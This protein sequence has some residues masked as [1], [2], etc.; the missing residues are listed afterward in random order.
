MHKEHGR[1]HRPQH[2]YTHDHYSLC[3]SYSSSSVSGSLAVSSRSSS[4]DIHS[5]YF[6]V[7]QTAGLASLPLSLLGRPRSVEARIA[8]LTSND[9]HGYVFFP[10]KATKQD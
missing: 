5:W 3:M 2:G 9:T 1:V 10:G 6:C 8:P 7:T 4:F